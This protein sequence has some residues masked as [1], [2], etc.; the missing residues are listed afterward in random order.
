MFE[1]TSANPWLCARLALK[2]SHSPTLP[3][4]G[5]ALPLETTSA[6]LW[7]AAHSKAFTLK[8]VMLTS[9]HHSLTCIKL[10]WPTRTAPSVCYPAP[11]QTK[12]AMGS[13]LDR[14]PSCPRTILPLINVEVLQLLQGRMDRSISTIHSLLEMVVMESKWDWEAISLSTTR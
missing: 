14:K 1:K 10:I 6:L 5:I 2:R 13:T 3:Y 8:E 11:F 9:A 4:R 7:I 12:Q